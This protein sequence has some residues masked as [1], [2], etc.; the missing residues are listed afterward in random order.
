MSPTEWTTS[1]PD[2]QGVELSD[3]ERALRRRYY[4]LEKIGSKGLL[5]HAVLLVIGIGVFAAV[6]GPKSTSSFLIGGG[7]AVMNLAVI[8][9]IVLQIAAHGVEKMGTYLLVFLGKFLVLA[10]V[11]AFVLLKYKPHGGPFIIG[12]STLIP[13]IFGITIARGRAK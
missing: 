1:P 7:F 3:D 12:Y 2:D 10:T 4:Q 11:L 6:T 5:A 13:V 8:N 9:W